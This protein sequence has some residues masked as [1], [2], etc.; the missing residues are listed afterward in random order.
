MNIKEYGQVENEW[1]RIRISDENGSGMKAE[2]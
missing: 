2:V 1:K